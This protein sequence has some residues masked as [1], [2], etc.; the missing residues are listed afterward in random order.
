[1]S[2][3]KQQEITISKTSI[4]K[5]IAAQCKDTNL[6]TKKSTKHKDMQNKLE[7]K[8]TSSIN[9]SNVSIT[10]S[11]SS[12]VVQKQQLKESST[13]LNKAL[14]SKK[15]KKS[16]SRPSSKNENKDKLSES[17]TN[18]NQSNQSIQ[19][20]DSTKSSTR[21]VTESSVSNDIISKGEDS[22]TNSIASLNSASLGVVPSSVISD[23][24]TSKSELE[25]GDSVNQSE[26]SISSLSNTNKTASLPIKSSKTDKINST[27]ASITSINSQ[28]ASSSNT[29]GIVTSSPIRRNRPRKDRPAP[30]PPINM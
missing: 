17:K 16:R 7:H 24:F 5:N 10:S 15:T 25:S 9:S 6:I 19:R 20:P 13:S 4:D 3:I 29:S 8:Q 11:N 26:T 2:N 27:T 18:L 22:T 23:Q 30:K 28:T 14:E 12:R 21:I 1:M